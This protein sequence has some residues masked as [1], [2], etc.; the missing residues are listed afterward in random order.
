MNFNSN[1]SQRTETTG[2]VSSVDC[3]FYFYPE[4]PWSR[5]E[6]GLVFAQLRDRFPDARWGKVRHDFRR[7]L[8][9]P[10]EPVDE[11]YLWNE[12]GTKAVR[13]IPHL[14]TI[15]HRAPYAGIDSLKADITD[16]V[17]AYRHATKPVGP[18]FTQGIEFRVV[19]DL[20]L[21]LTDQPV[22]TYFRIFPRSLQELSGGRQLGFDA[23]LRLFHEQEQTVATITVEDPSNFLSGRFRVVAGCYTTGSWSWDNTDVMSL[24]WVDRANALAWDAFDRVVT[25]AA[26]ASVNEDERIGR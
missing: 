26:L 3:T 8:E 19:V 25:D 16:A 13:L 4:K 9:A 17:S 7:R 20:T 11:V 14:M 2:A 23:T 18:S 10:L 6:E 21:P 12:L 15:T 24:R 22:D 1:P 5:T